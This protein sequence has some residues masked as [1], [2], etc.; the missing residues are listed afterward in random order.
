MVH[1]YFQGRNR[2]TDIENRLRKQGDKQTVEC[3][4]RAALTN[5]YAT[6]KTD[7]EQ[8]AAVQ[9]GELSS[10]LR[11]DW[12]GGAGDGREGVYAYIQLIPFKSQAEEERLSLFTI[13]D[14]SCCT[15]EMNRTL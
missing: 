7:S 12:R 1:I 5:I 9:H 14:S 3:I 4:E 11:D 6:S 2:G 10:V 13:A 8:E 15:A